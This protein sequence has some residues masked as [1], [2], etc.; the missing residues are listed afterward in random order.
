MKNLFLFLVVT[1]ASFGAQAI[2]VI[3]PTA[4]GFLGQVDLSPM[5]KICLS[6]GAGLAVVAALYFAI[7]TVLGLLSGNKVVVK[8]HG[9]WDTD[10]YESAMHDLQRHKNRG[11]ILDRESR[12]ALRDYQW[13]HPEV[14]ERESS[15]ASDH[16]R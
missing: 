11:G 15:W 16:A 4:G 13:E 14:L 1:L 6:V 10:V 8:G 3:A 12:D 9:I 2:P 5:F 7:S